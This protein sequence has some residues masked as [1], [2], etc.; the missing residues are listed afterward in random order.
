MILPW[1]ILIPFIGGMLCWMGVRLG[2]YITRLID[3]LLF[4]VYLYI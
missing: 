4:S 1:L 3:L 2:D